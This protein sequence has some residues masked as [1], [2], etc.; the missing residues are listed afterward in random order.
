MVKRVIGGTYRSFK[1]LLFFLIVALA[2][3]VSLGRYY[4]PKLTDY[5]QWIIEQVADNTGLKIDLA[6]LSGN[7]QAFSPGITVEGFRLYGANDAGQQEVL[8]VDELSV[9]FA[10]LAS[11]SHGQPIF[12]RLSL[13]GVKVVLKQRADGSWGLPGFLPGRQPKKGRSDGLATLREMLDESQ[14]LT[15]KNSHIQLLANNGRK[16]ELGNLTL[17]VHQSDDL[18][19]GQ[20]SINT[21]DDGFTPLVAKLEGD[22]DLFSDRLKMTAEVSFNDA[23]LAYFQPLAP[24]YIPNSLL[25]TGKVLVSY[26]AEEGLIANSEVDFTHLDINN[27]TTKPVPVIMQLGGSFS[28]AY[29]PGG[30][31]QLYVRDL[32][33]DWFES[34]AIDRFSASYSPD[35]G[36]S[37]A[38]SAVDL[39]VLSQ[40]V[41]D[42]GLLS[43]KAEEALTTLSPKGNLNNLHWQY[44]PKQA[45]VDRLLLRAELSGVAVSSWKGAPG[46]NQLSGY[47]QAGTLSGFVDLDDTPLQL[48]FPKIYHE[49]LSFDKAKGRVAW[50]VGDRV[51]VNSGPIAVSADF[52]E[53]KVQ[54]DLDLAK[55]HEDPDPS[56]M[57]L[58][59]GLRDSEASYRDN[60]IPYVLPKPLLDWLQRGVKAG[61]IN[62]AGFIYH[63]EFTPGFGK[64]IQLAV[65]LDSGQ[66][67]FQEQWPMLQGIAGR[68]DVDN[69]NTAMRVDHASLLGVELHDAKVKVSPDRDNLVLAVKSKLSGESHSVLRL[70]KETPLAVMTG[71]VFDGWRASGNTVAAIDL[72]LP[73]TKGKQSPYVDVVAQLRNTAVSIDTLGL[74]LDKINGP[75]NYNSVRGLSSQGLKGR[76]WKQP[77][78]AVLLTKN[79]RENGKKQQNFIL[80]GHGIVGA[81]QLRAWTKQPIMGFLSGQTA[82]SSELTL[83]PGKRRQQQSELIVESD[84]KGFEVDLPAPYHKQKEQSWPLKIKLPVTSEGRLVVFSLQDRAQLQLQYAGKDISRAGLQLGNQWQPMSHRHG[85]RITGHVPMLSLSPWLDAIA[86]YRAMA[87]QHSEQAANPKVVTK[88][89]AQF[90]MAL[91]IDRLN[92]FN[93]TLLSAETIINRTESGWDISI[94]NEKVAAK[95]LLSDNSDELKIDIDRLAYPFLESQSGPDTHPVD[96]KAIEATKADDADPL[97][98]IDPAG[99]PVMQVVMNSV[100]INGE[101][102][103][104]W[105]FHAKPFQQG[106][107]VEGLEASLRGVNIAGMEKGQG[108]QLN[109]QRDGDHHSTQFKGALRA[110]DIG[111]VLEAWGLPKV[112]TSESADFH[113]QVG[114]QGSPVLMALPRYDGSISLD[115][116]EGQFIQT[117]GSPVEALK[118]FG[119]LNFANIARRLQ[120]DFSDLYKK[121]LSY[122]KVDGT[123]YFKQGLMQID[124]PL[125]VHGPSSDFKLSGLFDLKEEQVDAELVVTLPITTNL[126][127]VVALAG[128]IPTGGAAL[129]AAAGVYLASKLFESQLDSLS[130]AVYSINGS[131]SDPNFKF[132]RVFDVESKKN[133]DSA[134]PQDK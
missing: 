67:E 124:E 99:F 131:W 18:L 133:T 66:L 40:T 84:L 82:F 56:T 15:I 72:S 29:K 31:W 78:E 20:L 94:E 111:D 73:L 74:D 52:G 70:F 48:S 122:D 126:P 117:A 10:A 3:Y 88:P 12:D 61:H 7:W 128:A 121:G 58:L 30:E 33:T 116:D 8:V 65:A 25:A 44:Q 132:E 113:A 28:A 34:L 2:A 1:V 110:D 62:E 19:K 9:Q 123:V 63:G 39:G 76:L 77:V 32:K 112:I 38:V 118:L 68:L 93:Q 102:Y 109:W 85:L 51:A 47:L 24:H 95:V 105:K 46:A 104:R 11:L 64:S 23:Q 90:V 83:A 53:A 119:I 69:H 57:S 89:S 4:L 115:L 101:N 13:S 16:L 14:Q 27:L 91:N 125:Q 79:V 107:L 45:I 75:L 103:G 92:M 17:E 26:D 130:S 86:R 35:N 108:A 21:G 114:W 127:W 59:V 100:T 6:G 98:N 134:L 97:Q 49:A 106:V 41:L 60:F 96:V 120:L 80:Q 129:P 55:T 37:G 71:H 54:L 81:E 50:H 22:G 42:A 5:R 43:G 87:A 36:F